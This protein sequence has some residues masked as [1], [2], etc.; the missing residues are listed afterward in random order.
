MPNRLPFL[1]AQGGQPLT[2]YLDTNGD[3]T[4]TKNATGDYSGGAN[5]FIQPPAGEVYTLHRMIIS[6]SDAS[7]RAD[8]YGGLGSALS[9]GI[10]VTLQNSTGMLSLV[11]G[12]P[13]KLNSDWNHLA[14]DRQ[15]DAYGSATVENLSI[16]WSFDKFG[17]ALVLNGDRADKLIVE[18]S[19]DLTGLVNHLFMVQGQRVQTR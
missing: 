9:N 7:L 19:D 10:A 14:H 6:I 18:F 8:H 5:F 3:G 1:N 16:R 17:G 11:D 2:R 12:L 15:R 13:I 4:G